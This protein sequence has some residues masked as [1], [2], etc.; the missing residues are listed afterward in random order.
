M[1]KVIMIS[2]KQGSGKTTLG[3]AL[4]KEFSLSGHQV[5][6]L[7]FAS[8]IYQI[9]DYA[10]ALMEDKGLKLDSVKDGDLLQ[11]LG[12]EWGRE[13]FGEN[14]WA[15]CLKGDVKNYCE[16][17]PNK[18]IV[19]LVSD[20]RFENEFNAVEDALTVRLECSREV[21]KSRCEMWR[22]NDKHRSETDLDSHAMRGMFDITLNTEFD[23]VEHCVDA[24]INEKRNGL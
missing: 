12:T 13:K 10:L 14:V 22:E 4:A 21:R 16:K 19:F 8:T 5:V 20:C 18:N 15:D 9:H 11:F 24:I 3:H 1:H 6:G 2:G 7:T 17:F 23:T